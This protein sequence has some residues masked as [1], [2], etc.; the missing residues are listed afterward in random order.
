MNRYRIDWI[1]GSSPLTRGKRL[2]GIAT[3]L[4]PMAHPRSRGEN[5]CVVT[6]WLVATWLIPAHAG[7]TITISKALASLK[8][9]PRSRGENRTRGIDSPGFQGSSPLTRGKLV[10]GKG[11]K[12]RIGLIPAHAGKTRRGASR[13][14]RR[15][16]HPRSRGENSFL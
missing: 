14:C 1:Q 16:A 8:A 9:H 3:A 13:R 12:A 4:V 7:K 10:H 6:F 11:G 5:S 15:K 2:Y